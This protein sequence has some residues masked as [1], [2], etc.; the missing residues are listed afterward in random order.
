MGARGCPI[1]RAA[2]TMAESFQVPNFNGDWYPFIATTYDEGQTWVTVNAT[3]NDPV[4]RHKGVCLQG[5]D[6]GSDTSP[7]NFLDFN[8]A[9]LDEKGR[10]LFG[11]DDGCV[12][13]ECVAGTKGNDDK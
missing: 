9:T 3:P 1:S 11:Y 7:R 12:S 13:P 4:Q 6:C 10:M 5:I 8:E 2:P